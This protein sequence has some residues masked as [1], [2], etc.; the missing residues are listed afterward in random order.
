MNL[1]NTNEYSNMKVYKVL[2]LYEIPVEFEERY[3]F[4]PS[5]IYV[6]KCYED[7]YKLIT[8]I[9]IRNDKK[10]P[11]VLI[12]GVPGIGKSIFMIYF[13]CM[14]QSDENFKDKRFAFETNCG[15]YHFY[16]PTS[17]ENKCEYTCHKSVQSK[18]FQLS[19]VLVLS[20]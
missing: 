2:T 11:G 13:L 16:V 7:L 5:S 1:D 9:M 6:R 19:D 20:D 15:L 12:T 10:R 14:Y 3:G 17:E 18:D 4:I 8:N